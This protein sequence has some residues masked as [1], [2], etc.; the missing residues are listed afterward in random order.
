MDREE[1]KLRDQPDGDVFEPANMFEEYVGHFWGLPHSRPY[2]RARYALVEA[3]LKVRT[4]DAVVAALDHVMDCMRLCRS[5]NMGVRDLVPALLLRLGRDQEC[6]DFVKWWATTAERDHYDWGDMDEPFLDIKN[7]DVLE[8]PQYLCRRFLDLSHAV[9]ITLLK[10]KLLLA[11]RAGGEGWEILRS[12]QTF[13]Q[14]EDRITQ[15][16]TGECEKKPVEVIKV[17]RSHV[18]MLYQA[19]DQANP[20]FWGALISPG[21]HLEARP[22]YTSSGSKEEMQLSLQRSHD[23]W[24]ESPGAI[25]VINAILHKEDY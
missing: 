21:S 11:V 1:Q 19:V 5:D 24:K 12:S 3:I 18:D 20:H 13:N 9:S 15:T 6:Y 7:A 22:E 14:M 2:M 23:A 10:I 16:E 17:L 4:Y 8:S 25:E